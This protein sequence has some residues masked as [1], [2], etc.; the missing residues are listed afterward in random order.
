MKRTFKVEL[1]VVVDDP[2]G[3]LAIQLARDR[4]RTTGYASE[5][6]CDGSE[7]LREIPPEEFIPDVMSAIMEFSSANPLLETVG[8]EV[9]G[10]SCW[11]GQPEEGVLLQ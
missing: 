6:I 11:E 4:Y 2:N 5:P 9:I 7:D 10:V 3:D 1:E 8:I